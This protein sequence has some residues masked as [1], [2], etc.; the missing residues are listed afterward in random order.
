MRIKHSEQPEQSIRSL[1]SP[2]AG[3]PCPFALIEGP[4]AD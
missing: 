3:N 4:P 1:A 2:L